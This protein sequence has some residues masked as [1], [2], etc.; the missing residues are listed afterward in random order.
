MKYDS[1]GYNRNNITEYGDYR[2]SA[3]LTIPGCNDTR[4]HRIKNHASN[5]AMLLCHVP[6]ICK[7]CRR[8]GLTKRVIRHIRHRSI[9]AVDTQYEL[10]IF[11]EVLCAQYHS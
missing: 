3:Y 7:D 11:R 1:G 10:G 4:L 5:I 6:D 8:A 2:P 9:A